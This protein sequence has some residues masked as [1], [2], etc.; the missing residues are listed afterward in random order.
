[1]TRWLD[2]VPGNGRSHGH[3]RP[4]TLS[5]AVLILFLGLLAW[6][7]WATRNIDS[8]TGGPSGCVTYE[9]GAGTCDDGST[10]CLPHELCGRQSPPSPR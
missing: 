7:V 5:I 2:D 3:E 9:D 1:M 6:G 8:D 4:S 10:F